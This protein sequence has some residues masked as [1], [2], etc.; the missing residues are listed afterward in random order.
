MRNFQL[1][2]VCYDIADRRRSGRVRRVLKCWATPVQQSVFVFA[3]TPPSLGEL[4]SQL[5]GVI[6]P[7]VDDVRAYSLPSRPA[8]KF[9]GRAPLALGITWLPSGFGST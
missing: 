2:L 7:R 5:T 1:W 9:M 3:G 6:D 4:M 8:I